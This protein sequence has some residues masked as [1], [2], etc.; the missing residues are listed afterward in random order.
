MKIKAIEHNIYENAVPVY[1]VVNA[2]ELHNFIIKSDTNTDIVSHNCCMDE[3][4]FTRAG[5]KDIN[6][7]KNHMKQ[8][9]N[10]ANA[11]IT[12]TF[13]LKGKVYGKLFSCSSKN[14]DSDYLS[15]HIQ[16]QL[17]AGNEHMYLFDKPQWEV[18]PAEK[19]SDKRFYITIGDR[20]KK[21]FVVPKE[22]ED[23]LH[24]DEY[25]S[26]GYKL[27]QVPE[28]FRTNF[29]ADYD[30][31]LRDIAGISVVGAM[32]FITQEVITPC[33]SEDRINPFFEDIYWIVRK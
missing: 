27:L 20:F 21:G 13:R 15:E 17:D 9:Y 33:V 25:V 30:I 23:Q 4:N 29:N 31:A 26:Q 6:I 5:V 3:V 22:N 32:G 24:L 10:T 12:G 1:D 18:E 19:F 2:G 14:T 16:E 28:D 11:R 8:L 7:S